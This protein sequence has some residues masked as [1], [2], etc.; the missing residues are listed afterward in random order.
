MPESAPYSTVLIQCKY[1]V[2]TVLVQYLYGART[3]HVWCIQVYVES[4]VYGANH[5]LCGTQQ[6]PERKGG[7]VLPMG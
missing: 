6:Y 4:F 3:V 5:L 2:Y 7:M 1:G